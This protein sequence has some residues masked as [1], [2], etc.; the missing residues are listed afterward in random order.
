MIAP[1]VA[2]GRW[3]KGSQLFNQLQWR[4]HQMGRPIRPGVFEEGG[5]MVGEYL[6]ALL[7]VIDSF[8]W[9]ILDPPAGRN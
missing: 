9:P 3:D 8:R 2:S 5:E 4:Q 1:Q 7:R 6:P